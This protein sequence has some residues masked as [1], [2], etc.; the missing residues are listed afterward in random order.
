M[1]KSGWD[2]N[3]YPYDL[4]LSKGPGESLVEL[5]TPIRQ[6]LNQQENILSEDPYSSNPNLWKG[7]NAFSGSGDVT[8]EVVYANYGTKADFEKLKDWAAKN[9]LTETSNN[10]L[11][12]NKAVCDKIWSEVDR[13]NASFGNWEKVKKFA[14]LAQEFTIDGGELTPK[15]SLK[16]KVILTNTPS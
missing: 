1:K 14:L 15:L 7:W 6:P 12:K 13:L 8:A 16:I 11:I 10:E 5:V 9:N 4:Y 2:V 3:V